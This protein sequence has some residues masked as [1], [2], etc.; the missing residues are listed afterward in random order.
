MQPLLSEGNAIFKKLIG[1]PDEAKNGP[2]PTDLQDQFVRWR[3]K[4]LDAKPL[5]TSTVQ[6][7][8]EPYIRKLTV[9]LLAYYLERLLHEAA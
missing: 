4:L 2:A 9:R 6:D 1:L 5:R 3:R 8:Q 7:T